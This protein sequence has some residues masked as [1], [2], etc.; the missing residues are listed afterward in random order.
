I[1]ADMRKRDGLLAE[2]DF[3]DHSA[4]WVNPISTNYRGYDVYELPP[5][6]QGF[7]VLEMLNILEGFDVRSMGY[8][9]A[10]YVQPFFDAKRIACADRAAYLADPAFV[11]PAVLNALISKDYA[12][13]RRAEIDL[14]SASPSYKPGSFETLTTSGTSIAE[15]GQDWT[16]RARGDTIYMT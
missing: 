13:S 16:G 15:A 1:V 8:N 4:D 14:H 11:P 6:T 10:D 5:N 2:R 9:S 7:V 12:A 3:A